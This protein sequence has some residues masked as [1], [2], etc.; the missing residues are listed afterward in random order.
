MDNNL[1][2]NNPLTPYLQPSQQSEEGLM[3]FV[4]DIGEVYKKPHSKGKDYTFYTRDLKYNFI[5]RVDKDG[6]VTVATFEQNLVPNPV[7]ITQN[8]LSEK[9]GVLENGINNKMIAF[10]GR[11]Q[12]LEN[13]MDKL[14]SFMENK[15]N[16]S[17]GILQQQ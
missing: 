3:C 6:Q 1:L 10:N 5:K 8:E 11:L 14:I 4:D 16:E 17:S 12:T 7:P 2:I 13:K 9:I 15:Q